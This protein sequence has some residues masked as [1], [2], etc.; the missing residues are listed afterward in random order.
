M[1][2]VP[3]TP[4]PGLASGTTLSAEG[5]SGLLAPGASQ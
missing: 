1:L 5:V 2:T 4:S 3:A